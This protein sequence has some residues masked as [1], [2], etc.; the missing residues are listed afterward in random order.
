MDSGTMHSAAA[1]SRVAEAM[2]KDVISSGLIEAS[3]RSTS[4][5]AAR[6][7]IPTYQVALEKRAGGRRLS[8]IVTSLRKRNFGACTIEGF[9]IN[10]AI[11][12][13]AK[14]MK[15]AAGTTEKNSSSNLTVKSKLSRHPETPGPKELSSLHVENMV[16]RQEFYL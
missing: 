16:N 8:W 12:H 9:R 3:T 10:S 6:I 11:L 14:M 15:S 5:S 13:A 4:S 1:N 7:P 2:V